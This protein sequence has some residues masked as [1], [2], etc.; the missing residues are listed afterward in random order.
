M[1]GGLAITVFVVG[2]VVAILVHELGHLVT[3]K[4]F[5][6][7]ADRYFVG[8][9]P[10]LWSTRRG[11]TEYGLKAFPLGGFVRI[12]GMTP[13]D[14]RRLPVVDEVFHPQALAADRKAASQRHGGDPLE[15]DNLPD[16]TW[17]R[18]AQV[19]EERG[20]S[21]DVAERI[22]RRTRN[23]VPD[24]P[25]AADGRQALNEV[26]VTE[27]GDSERLGDLPYRLLHGDEGRFF[28]DRPAWQRA[29]VLVSGPATHILIAFAALLGSYLFLPQLTVEPVVAGVVPD[30]PAQQA[31]LQEGDRIVAVAGIRSTDYIELRDAIRNRPGLTTDL[32]IERDGSE[33]VVSVVPQRRADEATG[34]SIGFLGFSPTID[35]IRFTPSEAIEE[36]AIGRPDELGLSPG[37]VLPLVPASI[38]GLARVFSPQGLTALVSTASGQTDR[39]A[40][41]PVSIVGVANIA[42]QAEGGEQGL[43]FF[44]MLVAVV[45]VFFLVLNL[46]PLPPFDGGHLAVVGIEKVVNMVRSLSG[47]AQDFTVDPRAIVAVTLPVLAILGTVLV[48]TLWL[49]ITDPIRF[50]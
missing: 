14:E 9:G 29:V 25:T 35:E 36:A 31:G 4:R 3:A 38:E 6:M 15:Q 10:T 26:L 30:S 18:L 23:S 12:V 48:A 44:L 34:A 22:V 5:G 2:L 11:E 19:L 28:H 1:T 32:V 46:I 33:E 39:G 50:G 7:R 45:N 16:P 20:T 47:K 43:A 21:A 40:E 27:V 37:G 13:L 42:G 49:D 24:Y 8:F 41:T 17:E